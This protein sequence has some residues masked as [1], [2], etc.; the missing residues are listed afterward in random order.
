VNAAVP[1]GRETFCRTSR[2][3]IRDAQ[4]AAAGPAGG[5]VKVTLALQ[6]GLGQD[7]EVRARMQVSI[8]CNPCSRCCLCMFRDSF[9]VW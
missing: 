4:L 7:I 9:P 6:T 3:I 1:F 2:G 8:P 5:G